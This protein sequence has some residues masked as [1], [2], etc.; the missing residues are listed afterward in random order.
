MRRSPLPAGVVL[1][2]LVVTL[3]S[4]YL[5]TVRGFGT[6][7]VL[8]MS[9]SG[10]KYWDKYPIVD[11]TNAWRA[12]SFGDGT[13]LQGP[14]PLGYG[15]NPALRTTI[16]YGPS[17]T[18]R[19]VTTY[20]RNKFT[21][22]MQAGW[23]GSVNL[24]IAASDGAIVYINTV[25]VARVNMPLG[26]NDTGTL[27]AASAVTNMSTN[28]SR[29]VSVP[30]SVLSLGTAASNQIAVSVHQ[31]S[32]TSPNCYFDLGVSVTVFPTPSPSSTNTATATVTPSTSLTATATVTPSISAT[33]MPT[34]PEQVHFTDWWK[35][36]DDGVDMT[37]VF[38][39]SKYS[40]SSWKQGRG[41]LGTTMAAGCGSFI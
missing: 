13:W 11:P 6:A 2:A 5:Q 37:G 26:V 16:S 32:T 17:S 9:S 3:S 22:A 27:F 28:A 12:A 25:E 39:N 34:G 10:W 36:K 8:S 15:T 24:T 14:A 18:S 33:S 41:M 29:E 7:T 35:Y 40:D 31:K 20:F 4:M 1:T 38:I 30:L 23:G 19:Y 21:A